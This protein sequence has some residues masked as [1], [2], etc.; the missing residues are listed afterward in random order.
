[1]TGHHF[2]ALFL[3]H[4][5]Q[6]LNFVLLWLIIVVSEFLLVILEIS[7]SFLQDIKIALPLDAVNLVC[8]DTDVDI[9]SNHIRSL[10]HSLRQ[11]HVACNL[12]FQLFS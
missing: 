1:V 6:D 10:T 4:V 7:P 8:S 5:F 3:I 2:D 12:R 9:L 11:Y